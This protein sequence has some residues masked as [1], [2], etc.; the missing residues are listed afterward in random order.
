MR[1]T[2]I[3]F[4]I[5]F[6]GKGGSEK[7][8]EELARIFT[9]RGERCFLCYNVPGQ[10]CSRMEALGIECVQLGISARG[11]LRSARGLANI[12]R[13]REI[14]VIHAQYPAENIVALLS[15]RWYAR[16]N[17]VYTGHLTIDGGAKWRIINRIFTP[18]DKAVI[19][20]CSAGREALIHNGVCPERIEVIYNGVEPCAAPRRDKSARAA[21]GVGEDDFLISC[22][23]RC[24]PEK[25][26]PFLIDAMAAL[27][28]RTARPFKCLICGDGE[29]LDEARARVCAL[30]LDGVVIL[31]G[32]RTDTADI[33]AASDLYVNSSASEAMSFALLEAMNAGLPLVVTD[34]PGNREL[35]LDADYPCGLTAGYGD[36]AGFAAAVER[37]MAGPELYARC[38]ANALARIRRDFDIEKLAAKTLE[39]YR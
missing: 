10:L 26:V 27:A 13:E 36:A 33:L 8:V 18:K 15:K 23:A 12:C 7:Y 9:R 35:A 37:M 34:L 6:A 39:T 5:N 38:S 30:G 19:A 25:G 3:L 14:D 31:P 28:A 24:S 4:L 22:F 32:Y 20:V 29:L 1:R 17:V 11:A 21:L 2:N 16:P